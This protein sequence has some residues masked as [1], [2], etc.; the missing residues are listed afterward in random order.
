M[1][2][3]KNKYIPPKTASSEKNDQF[4]FKKLIAI[5]LVVNLLTTGISFAY[6]IETGSSYDA[7]RVAKFAVQA[8]L[9]VDVSEAVII[10]GSDDQSVSY[11]ITIHN[12][13]EVGVTCSAVLTYA[14]TD[15]GT[16][17]KIRV[18]CQLGDNAQT[19]PVSLSKTNTFNN[20]GGIAPGSDGILKLI[21]QTNRN[22]D[23]DY[24]NEFVYGLKLALTILRYN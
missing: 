3:R 23:E 24:I 4:S 18:S 2:K 13:S 1:K 6:C 16:A 20:L 11:S 12:Y 22:Y 14:D 9:P 8:E 21:F 17:G 19:T 10:K 7:A 5:L 15:T